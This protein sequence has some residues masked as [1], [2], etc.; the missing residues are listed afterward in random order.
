MP[1]PEAGID[2]ALYRL[3][4]DGTFTRVVDGV[5]LPNGMGFTPDR[6]GM[7]FTDTCEHDPDCPGLLY[8]FDY[9]RETGAL[10]DRTTL[11]EVDDREGL[12]DGMTVDAEGYLWSAMWDGN[13]LVRYDPDGEPVASVPF[14][15][16]KVSSVTFGGP[17]YRDAYVTTAGGD[18]R[19]TEGAG[20]GSLFWVDLGVAGVPE[21]RSRIGLDAD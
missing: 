14:E 11:V 9:D 8:R 10:G 20:A 4:R 16:R 2:G 3:D 15:P 7:Y 19:E 18:D 12:P 21:F 13:E 17:D 6:D 5:G 1:D